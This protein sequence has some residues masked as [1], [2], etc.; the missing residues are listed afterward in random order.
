MLSFYPVS[1]YISSLC[2]N[3]SVSP[4]VP[5]ACLFLPYYIC[6]YF[7]F[8]LSLLLFIPVSISLP[9]SLPYLCFFTTGPCPLPFPP[10]PGSSTLFPSP[11]SHMAGVLLVLASASART[12]W[13][14]TREHRVHCRSSPTPLRYSPRGALGSLPGVLSIRSA[15]TGWA[16][17]PSERPDT[18]IS[19]L[20][21]HQPTPAGKP[22]RSPPG[23]RA[24]GGDADVLDGIRRERTRFL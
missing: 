3:V 18:P 9:V 14:G 13:G 11:I 24:L 15:S 7:Y 16:E 1:L 10:L 20:T 23:A 21:I 22:G 19:R 8:S 2:V 17:E 12:C 5:C 6:L 4:G